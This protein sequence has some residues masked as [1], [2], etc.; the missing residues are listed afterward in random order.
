MGMG[1]RAGSH[2]SLT[3]LSI[4]KVQNGLCAR[5]A[6]LFATFSALFMSIML[7]PETQSIRAGRTAAARTYVRASRPQAIVMIDL[8]ATK[9]PLIAA[10]GRWP[11]RIGGKSAWRVMGE[12]RA[13][14]TRIPSP[15]P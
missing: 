7:R 12:Q 8:C 4:R 14:P 11:H 6:P 3:S 1:E 2:A 15:L 9:R 5:V 13:K 10:S